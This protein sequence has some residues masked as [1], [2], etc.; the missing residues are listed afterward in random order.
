MCNLKSKVRDS[1]LVKMERNLNKEQMDIL[2]AILEDEFVLINMEAIST[3][4]AVIDKSVEEKNRYLIN[5]FLLK[6]KNLADNTLQQYINA[7][8]RLVAAVDK[9]LTEIDDMDVEYYLRQYENRNKF[10]TGKKNCAQTVNNERRFLSA[11]FTWL[12]KAKFIQDNPVE[13]VEEKKVERKP[14]DFFRPEQLETLREGCKALRDRAI[15]EVL[16]STGAR[17]GEI[18]PI[19]R[20]DIDWTTGDILILGEKGGRYRTVYLDEAAR[21]HLKKYMFSRKDNTEALFAHERAPYNRL[22]TCGIRSVLKEIAKRQGVKY[23]VYP[24]KLRK[25][26]GMDLKKRG[27]DIGIIQEVL[28]HQDPATTSRYYAESTPDTLRDVRKRMAA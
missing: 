18:V 2:T 24:H 20:E 27:A 15:V 4:P 17:V 26:L 28:G 13:S 7:V 12:R 16:R 21:Y 14:I 5:L 1:V 23:R 6:K 10:T 3:L 9:A 19:N 8:S 22:Q 25:T 11:Y